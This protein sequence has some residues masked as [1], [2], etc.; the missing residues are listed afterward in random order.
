MTAV[1]EKMPPHPWLYRVIFLVCSALLTMGLYASLWTENQAVCTSPETLS[2]HSMPEE[3]RLHRDRDLSRLADIVVRSPREAL[4]LLLE[5]YPIPED[6]VLIETEDFWGWKTSYTP[7][8]GNQTP[9]AQQSSTQ[10]CYYRLTPNEK[11]YEFWL[12]SSL[13]DMPSTG[14]G[15]CSTLNFY[16]VNI[17]TREILVQRTDTWDYIENHVYKKAITQ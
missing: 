3:H 4:E 9:D 2:L 10:L 12:Y 16:A 15:H 13:L 14:E 7:V 5:A 17:Y 6:A 8:G 11:Y 1:G